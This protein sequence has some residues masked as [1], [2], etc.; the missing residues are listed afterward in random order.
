MRIKLKRLPMKRLRQ[1][2][3]V[4]LSLYLLYLV[5]SALGINLSNKYSAWGIF[6]LPIRSLLHSKT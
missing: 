2:L 6:K 4:V 3:L 1:I 5:K